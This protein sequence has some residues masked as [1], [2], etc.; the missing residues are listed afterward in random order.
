MKRHGDTAVDTEYSVVVQVYHS[1]NIQD[2]IGAGASDGQPMQASHFLIDRVRI[3]DR[4]G[5]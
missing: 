5:G 4:G 1:I 2:L 3:A